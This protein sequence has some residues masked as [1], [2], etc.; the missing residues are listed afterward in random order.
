MYV[1]IPGRETLDLR[2]LV[3]DFNGTLAKDGHIQEGVVPLLARLAAEYEI[4]VLT[5]DTFGT[6]AAQCKG[7]PVRLQCLPGEHQVAAKEAYVRSLGV[8]RVAAVGNGAND[9]GM[10]ATAALGLAVLGPEGCAREALFVANIVVGSITDG[11][12]LLLS[13][14]RLVA[15]L[16]R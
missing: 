13:P 6:V 8:S 3:L 10:L 15:T 1:A 12:E 4:H 14:N 9:A 2:F 11:L 5:A 7:L 16:R